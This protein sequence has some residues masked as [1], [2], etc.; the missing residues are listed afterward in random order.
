M[1][2]VGSYCGEEEHLVVASTSRVS[3]RCHLSLQEEW[4]LEERSGY[5]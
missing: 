1:A 5:S 2:N 3:V 4:G